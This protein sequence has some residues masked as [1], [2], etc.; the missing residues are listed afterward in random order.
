MSG[1]YAITETGAP[2]NVA[3]ER[4]VDDRFD[5]ETEQINPSGWHV[6]AENPDTAESG[7]LTVYVTCADRAPL[8]TP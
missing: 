6:N 5:L 4:R 7:D 1:S 8:H 2:L 3:S